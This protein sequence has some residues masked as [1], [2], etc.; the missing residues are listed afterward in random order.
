MAVAVL[1]L[2]SSTKPLSAVPP[3]NKKAAVVEVQ[4]VLRR[5]LAAGKRLPAPPFATKIAVPFRTPLKFSAVP[6]F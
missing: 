4:K 2:P 1:P 5:R 6:L 3:P